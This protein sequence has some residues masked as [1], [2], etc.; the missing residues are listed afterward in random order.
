MRIIAPLFTLLFQMFVTGIVLAIVYFVYAIIDA[1][2]TGFD[3]L[4]GFIL[5][6]PI[7]GG[8]LILTTMLVCIIVGLPIRLNRSLREWWIRKPLIP[9]VGSMLGLILSVVA[10][11]P[12]LSDIHHVMVEGE[13]V[14]KETPNILFSCSGWLMISFFLLHLFPQSAALYIRFENKKDQFK[15]R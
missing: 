5:F 9:I 6:Q 13:W 7:F 10:F 11:Y 4:V 3:F 15:V 12:S 8:L 1:D 14:K 2:Y